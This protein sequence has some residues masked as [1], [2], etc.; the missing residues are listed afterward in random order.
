VT[1]RREF[2]VATGTQAVGLAALGGAGVAFGARERPTRVTAERE[3]AGAAARSGP[4]ARLGV[5]RVVWSTDPVGPYAAITFDDGPTPEFTPRILVALERAGARATFNV[6]GHNAVAHPHLIREIVAAGHEIGNHTMTHLDLAQI[7][8]PRIRQEI[9][10]CK[11]EVEQLVQQPLMGFRPPR[12]EL[13]G[14]ALMVAAELGYDV[15]MW[16]CTRGPAGVST[17]A[18]VAGA[19]GTA[20]QAGDVVDLHDGIGRGTFAPTARFARAL[21]ARREVE[22]QAL[23]EALR[24]IAD[25]GVVLTS[26]T[27][28]LARS[29]P[30]PLPA[31]QQPAQAP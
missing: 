28:L 18:A 5:R 22:V 1:S 17:P 29:R 11:D 20:V 15:F 8:T 9:V 6:M 31:W 23:P 27:D 16:S 14:Y 24:R 19:L 3:A 25:R 30:E 4:G 10:Q 13:S 2:L 12:G 21:A 7:S 26:A